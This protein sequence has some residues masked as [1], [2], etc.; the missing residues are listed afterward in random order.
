MRKISVGQTLSAAYSFT[1]NNYLRILGVTWFP[2][3]VL[4][5]FMFWQFVPFMADMVP[6]T[7]AN[8]PQTMMA[9]LSHVFLFELVSFFVVVLI[10]AGVTKLA[11]G[12]DLKWPF[13]YVALDGDYWRLVLSFFLA[14]LIFFGIILVTSIIMG[15]V[16]G[17]AA[18]SMAGPHPDP[19]QIRL[20]VAKLT[21]LIALPV[22]AIMLVLAIKFGFLLT[23]IVITE[24]KIGLGRNWSLTNGNF[25]RLF[26][27][28]LGLLVPFLV[29]TVLQYLLLSALGGPAMNILNAFKSPEAQ[30]LFNANLMNLYRTYWYVIV[31][32]GELF[33][34]VIYGLF[35]GGSA[36]AYRALVPDAVHADTFE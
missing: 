2:T 27:V 25:W 35:L 22:Y 1:I 33:S 19:E 16:V 10:C 32:V 13:F 28:L 14:A 15:A 17:V 7:A 12:R 5:A 4:F 24:K 6:G 30:M 11:L 29:L 34:P 36:F 3:A 31:V 23:P 9:S 8:D 21:L 20:G 26:V 18:V